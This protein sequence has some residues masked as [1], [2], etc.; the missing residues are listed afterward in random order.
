MID[1][2]LP[3]FI[4]RKHPKKG[5]E[6]ETNGKDQSPGKQIAQKRPAT[7]GGKGT[8][9]YRNL[10]QSHEAYPLKKG[11]VDLIF[12]ILWLWRL[13]IEIVFLKITINPIELFFQKSFC[14]SGGFRLRWLT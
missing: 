7:Y 13:E 4:K 2:T 6:K 11:E 5:R 9:K 8:A 3:N 14:N 12:G 10:H 1:E